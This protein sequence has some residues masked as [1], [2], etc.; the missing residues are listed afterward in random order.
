[1]LRTSKVIKNDISDF[2]QAIIDNMTA[3]DAI[4]CIRAIRVEYFNTGK[5]SKWTVA[6]DMAIKALED[7]PTEK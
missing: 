4:E 7:K 1:M 2:E 3:E 6:C 5:I